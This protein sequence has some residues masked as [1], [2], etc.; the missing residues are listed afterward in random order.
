MRLSTDCE[1][2]DRLELRTPAARR[3]AEAHQLARQIAHAKADAPYYRELFAGV[4]PTTITTRKALAQ[5]PITR[6]SDLMESQAKCRPFGGLNGWNVGRLA[7]IYQSPGPI[8][9][10]DGGI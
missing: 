3:R 2:Y 10:P 1:Y 4:D 5:L 7:R 9:E 6:K 8:Y